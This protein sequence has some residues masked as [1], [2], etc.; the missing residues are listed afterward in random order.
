MINCKQNFNDQSVAQAAHK[1]KPEELMSFG[2]STPNKECPTSSHQLSNSS[3]SSSIDDVGGGGGGGDSNVSELDISEQSMNP[4]Q[5]EDLIM[6]SSSSESSGVNQGTI[7]ERDEL[8]TSNTEV[9]KNSSVDAMDEMQTAQ[10][11]VPVTKQSSSVPEYKVSLTIL[12]I[13]TTKIQFQQIL[14]FPTVSSSVY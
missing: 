8:E 7:S 1:R 12:H 3:L 11:S 13:Y 6:F 4:N 5:P 2:S 10:S 9:I 14:Q